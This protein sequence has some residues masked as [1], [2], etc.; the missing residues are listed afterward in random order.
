MGGQD[1]PHDVRLLGVQVA[2]CEARLPARHRTDQ[3]HGWGYVEY[4]VL[5]SKVRSLLGVA[6]ALAVAA[7]YAPNPP[8][9][10]PCNDKLADSCPTEQQCV[11]G[12]CAAGSNGGAPDAP[13]GDA[14]APVDCDSADAC[15]TSVTLGSVSGDTGDEMLSATGSRA[16][17]YRVRVIENDATLTGRPVRVLAKLALPASAELDVRIYVNV[18]TDVLEC[19]TPIATAVSTGNLRVA[20][21]SWGET[22]IPNGADDSR[23]VEIEIRPITGTCLPTEHWE[24]TVEGNWN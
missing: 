5:P 18:T 15:L 9:G 11:A 1:K 21:A 4:G 3:R 6:A 24:L 20:R 16:A 23:D 12:Y 2:R 22:T 10:A 8:P 7:C 14:P 19:T 13:T 17:W